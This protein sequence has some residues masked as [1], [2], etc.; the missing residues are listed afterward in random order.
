MYRVHG[1]ALSTKL[2][3]CLSCVEH[4]WFRYR[5]GRGRTGGLDRARRLIPSRPGSVDSY[6]RECASRMGVR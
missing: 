4:F 3:S 5:R 2:S 6:G 1:S